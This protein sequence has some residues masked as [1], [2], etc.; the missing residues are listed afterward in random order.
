MKNTAPKR[1]R[2]PSISVLFAFIS[3]MVSGSAWALGDLRS[4]DPEDRSQ[5]WSFGFAY[6]LEDVI[7]AGEERSGTDLV[8]L[9]TYSG[10]HLFLDSTDFG[11]HAVDTSDWQLDLFAS[12]FIQGYNDHSFFYE[13]GAVRPPDDALKGMVRKNTV[14]AGV[15]LTRKTDFGRFSLQLRQ[16]AHGVHD[17]SEARA[18]WAKVFRGNQWQVEPWAEYNVLSGE[19]ADYYYGVRD[20]ESTDTRPTY[21]LDEGSIWGIGIAGRYSLWEN[22]QFNVNLAYRAYGGDIAASPI[23]ARDTGTSVQFAYRYEFGG[24][25]RPAGDGEFDFVT[26]NA[27]PTAVRLAYGC[28]TEAKFV[29]ILQGDINCADLD[30]GLGSVFVSRQ[31]TERMATLPIEGWLQLGL[32]RRFQNNLQ[33]DFWEGVFAFKALFRQFPWSDT[34]E[35][36]LGFSNG[37]SYA[38]RV[39]ALEQVKAARKNRRESHL[40]HYLEFSLDVSVGDL[41]GVDSLR[42]LFA[43][44][45][46]HHRSGIFSHA[47]YYKNVY[48]GSNANMLYFEWEF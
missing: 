44:F 47:D 6:I 8:P 37:V 28:T 38:G 2:Q 15:E 5:E 7:Y 11:W 10:K 23:V 45:Y 16:D 41:L 22:H 27:R 31:L 18:R 3:L 9:F 42:N 30:T 17:G 48:G 26:N 24:E 34:V 33:D 39:P 14:E 21:T 1:T 13:T 29:K 12:Y 20:D 4:L 36:R 32:G 40:L 35:T 19:K 43:G 25:K 46:V